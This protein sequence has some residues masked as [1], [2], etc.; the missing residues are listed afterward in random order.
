MVQNG[1]STESQVKNHNFS[2]TEDLSLWRQVNL[3]RNSY[4]NLEIELVIF[5]AITE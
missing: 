4:L 1:S 2:M 3:W 5:I